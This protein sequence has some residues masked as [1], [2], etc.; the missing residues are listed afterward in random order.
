MRNEK[1]LSSFV[2]NSPSIETS[3]LTLVLHLTVCCN[4]RPAD[5]KFRT[6]WSPPEE[7]ARADASQPFGFLVHIFVVAVTATLLVVLWLLCD[8]SIAG[9]QQS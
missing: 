2:L 3:V 7:D 4:V 6:Q 1:G 5:W 8:Q 9:Q